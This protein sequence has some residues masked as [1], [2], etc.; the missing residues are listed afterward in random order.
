MTEGMRP[1]A[2]FQLKRRSANGLNGFTLIELLVVIA[3]I[4][5]LAG[6]LLPVLGKARMK[7]QGIYCMNN[8]KQLQVAWFMYADDHQGRLP[9]NVGGNYGNWVG[10]SMELGA[11]PVGADSTNIFLLVDRVRSVMGPYIQNPNI[12]R[13]PADKSRV[14]VG[15]DAAHPRV[16]SM[17]MNN[18]MNGSDLE[19]PN[20]VIFRRAADI[21]NPAPANAWVFIDEHED[22]INDAMF[23]VDMRGFGR[24]LTVIDW[25]AYYHNGA[26]GVSFADG[27]AEIHKWRDSRTR[28]P[29]TGRDLG[30]E[31]SPNNVD[32]MWLQERSTSLK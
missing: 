10:G 15:R 1:P 26:G 12:F 16:R 17:A 20:F 4:A 9:P 11:V 8:L 19:A 30:R 29:V 13:C 27:H 31:P 22:S 3:I 2:I 18:W 5:I 6:L 25:P 7:G 28:K 23:G 24:A 21:I 32:F 14:T